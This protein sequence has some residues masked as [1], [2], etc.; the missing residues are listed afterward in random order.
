MNELHNYYRTLGLEPGATL[1]KVLEKHKF[2]SQVMHPDLIQFPKKKK[3]AEEEMKKYNNAKDK[4]KEHL[5][6]SEHR[7]SGACACRMAAGGESK[8]N[9]EPRNNTHKEKEERYK[10]QKEAEE[11]ARRRAEERRREQEAE[12]KQQAEEQAAKEKEQAEVARQQQLQQAF[13]QQQIEEAAKWR[14]TAFQIQFVVFVMLFI[15]TC[16]VNLSKAL[17]NTEPED[18]PEMKQD[19]ERIA[20]IRSQI[21]ARASALETEKKREWW[22]VTGADNYPAKWRNQ[23]IDVPP[24]LPITPL[25]ELPTDRLLFVDSADPGQK[26]MNSEQLREKLLEME[27]ARR[28]AEER[29][30]VEE[31]RQ[32]AQQ[33]LENAPKTN[34]QNANLQGES[35]GPDRR[36]SDGSQNPASTVDPGLE[37][38]GPSTSGSEGF[39]YSGFKQPL[40][41]GRTLPAQTPNAQFADPPEQDWAKNAARRREIELDPSGVHR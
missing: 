15:G 38:H 26:I 34:N 41:A 36:G 4:L 11:N 40:P 39:D 18:T 19:K 8:A 14:W 9:S 7:M 24:Q 30:K 17:G 25:S 27:A 28:R 23:P 12:A 35:I 13:E 32:S 21:T 3:Q 5:T 29:K 31:V 33:Y 2:L 1:E 10:K 6:S 16:C 37:I 20:N 22:R